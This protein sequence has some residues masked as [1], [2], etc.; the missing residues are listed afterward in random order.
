MANQMKEPRSDTRL[1]LP[2][3]LQR[4]ALQII[5]VVALSL[6]F[7]LAM[8]SH[9]G[10]AILFIG[11]PVILFF[12]LRI[13]YPSGDAKS[14]VSTT[15]GGRVRVLRLLN[16]RQCRRQ[17]PGVWKCARIRSS[18]R[19]PIFIAVRQWRLIAF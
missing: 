4:V 7:P 6:G 15:H 14:Q 1:R 18:R 12:L 16:A 17:M 13:I 10:I 8:E 11:T 2:V 9:Y 19:S 5:A 3:H